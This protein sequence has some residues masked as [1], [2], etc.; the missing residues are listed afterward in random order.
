M[1]VVGA[2]PPDVFQLMTTE[3]FARTRSLEIETSLRATPWSAASRMDE[4]IFSSAGEYR[5]FVSEN[6][7]SEYGGYWCKVKFVA[8]KK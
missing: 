1:L 6:M 4:V 2:P 5:I 3:E 7:E 8:R